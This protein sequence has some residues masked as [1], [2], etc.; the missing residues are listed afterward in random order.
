MAHNGAQPHLRSLAIDMAGFGAVSLSYTPEGASLGGSTHIRF[1]SSPWPAPAP[2]PPPTHNIFEP[3]ASAPASTS[4]QKAP[5]HDPRA[6]TPS[7]LPSSTLPSSRPCPGQRAAEHVEPLE[8]AQSTE[9]ALP[10]PPS[11]PTPSRI[12][13]MPVPWEDLTARSMPVHATQ[14]LLPCGHAPAIPQPAPSVTEPS[15]PAL[16]MASR[17]SASCVPETQ[18]DW[19]APLRSRSVR[20]PQAIPARGQIPALSPKPA[21]SVTEPS[22]PAPSMASRRSAS[23]MPETQQESFDPNETFSFELDRLA[24]LKRPFEPTQGFYAMLEEHDAQQ[25]LEPTAGL[26]AAP[27]VTV[28]AH[29]TPFSQVSSG[30]RPMPTSPA[31]R[32]RVDEPGGPGIV[33]EPWHSRLPS[34]PRGREYLTAPRT[35]SRTEYLT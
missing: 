18:R 33:H 11:T 28:H 26:L 2:Q 23:S 21:P 25:S 13:R 3:A 6:D 27:R 29:G 9:P 7:H 8:P 32:A 4:T 31:K 10:D 35:P 16:S 17:R 24:G 20:T 15:S 22:S 19:Q 1:S 34:S 30:S 12:A 14:A 5:P